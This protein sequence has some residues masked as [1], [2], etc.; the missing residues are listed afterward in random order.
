ML[1]SNAKEFYVR[2]G[3]ILSDQEQNK[4]QRGYGEEATK[5]KIA[6][7][8]GFSP[9]PQDGPN[10][11]AQSVKHECN[12][13][14][15]YI[16]QSY[17]SV[18]SCPAG[19][20]APYIDLK[21]GNIWEPGREWVHFTRHTW[22]ETSPGSISSTILS[23]KVY[24]TE[25]EAVLAA[26]IRGQNEVVAWREQLDMIKETVFSET[27]PDFRLTTERWEQTSQNVDSLLDWLNYMETKL[28]TE[29]PFDASVAGKISAVPTEPE[30]SENMPVEIIDAEFKTG[31][32]TLGGDD[33][34]P[35]YRSD[36]E[37]NHIDVQLS[38]LQE[39]IYA[40]QGEIKEIK[41]A[42]LAGVENELLNKKRSIAMMTFACTYYQIERA[43]AEARA[44]SKLEALILCAYV[45]AGA[46]QL[47][48]KVGTRQNVQEDEVTYGIEC[49]HVFGEFRDGWDML[50]PVP[51]EAA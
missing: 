25:C 50:K 24:N 38:H 34:F 45:V 4:G 48:T 37:I 32:A 23:V 39:A 16:R 36:E 49:V 40:A 26:V 2:K 29:N 33:V 31:Q 11:W 44:K 12:V 35:R 20:F 28:C 42:A 17:I 14:R 15:S 47:M 8:L 10:Y 51:D 7:L 21:A 5:N 19:L 22:P 18:F 43:L 41:E 46:K 9:N 30:P 13:D 27:D 6:A 1:V 3:E